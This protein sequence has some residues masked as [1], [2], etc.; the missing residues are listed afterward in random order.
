MPKV[1]QKYFIAIVPEGNLQQQATDLKLM[2]K[3]K[4]NLKYALRSPAH[5]TLK[6]PF[7]WNE[8]KEERLCASLEP[9]FATQ[10]AFGLNFSGIG[11]F[12]ERV[13]YIKVKKNGLLSK[14]QSELAWLC[15]RELNQKQELSDYAYHPHMT[16]A[17]KDVK[18]KHF[19]EY[20]EAVKAIGFSGKMQVE[21]V[22]LLKKLHGEPWTIL[23]SFPLSKDHVSP[24]M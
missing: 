22:T 21:K 14:L 3:D 8:A 6:M 18:K 11:N 19:P 5:V 15:Q 10:S 17:F 12:G 23:R 1:L 16:V 20:L 7:L 2:L 4:F 13:I 24:G 9:F